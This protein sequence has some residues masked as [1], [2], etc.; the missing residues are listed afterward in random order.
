MEVGL[1]VF[2]YNMI[3]EQE[4]RNLPLRSRN[5]TSSGATHVVNATKDA[6]E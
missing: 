3:T 5:A 6:G 1:R 4:L 2:A